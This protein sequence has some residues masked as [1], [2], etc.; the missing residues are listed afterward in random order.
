MIEEGIVIAVHGETAE[1]KVGRHTECSGCGACGSSKNA[2][3]LLYNE[4]NASVGDRV[5]FSMPEENI[6]AGAFIV[7][8]FPLIFAGIGAS[9]AFIFFPG[10]IPHLAA[11]FFL[12]SLIFVK[13]YDKRKRYD[14]KHNAKILE[15][16]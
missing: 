9:V 3:A 4:V 2:V 14:L 1:V 11:L 8:I 16:I 10:F 15:I 6:I 13:L 7:F 12:F 5:K